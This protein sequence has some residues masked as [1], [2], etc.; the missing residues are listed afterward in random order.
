[1]VSNKQ[2]A[3]KEWIDKLV[4]PI[5]NDTLSGAAEIAL[6]AIVVFKSIINHEQSIDASILK[7]NLNLT[8]QKLV[9]AQ[10]AMASLV[11]LSNLIAKSMK[12]S[13]STDE[14]RK[15]CLE[16]LNQFE[17]VLCDSVSK[18]ADTTFDILPPGEIIFAYSFSSTVVSCLLNAR[19]KGRYF[20]VACSE[21]RPS[22]EGRKLATRLAAGG[23][24]V[25]FTVDSAMGLILP[26]CSMALMG[27]DCISNPG[28]VN[29]SGSLL[30]SLAC[31]EMKIPLYAVSD[32]TK[33]IDED[34]FFEFENHERPGAEIWNDAP[35]E[36]TI[37]NR[38]FELIPFDHITGLIT[39][40]GLFTAKELP[41]Y[42]SK[43][44]NQQG[45]QAVR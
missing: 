10:P 42:I 20:R 1:M 9:D 40:N 5:R 4:E 35:S 44:Q 36:V 24:E 28:I 34:R 6:Q 22:M 32:T 41:A 17:T 39:E 25:I 37:L 30:L 33:F 31:T 14:I 7:E 15:N 26:S 12:N 3:N 18:I 19:A 11:N 29:K 21:S 8:S 2:N 13:N 43:L 45:L 38:Q 27:C 16:T 23:I